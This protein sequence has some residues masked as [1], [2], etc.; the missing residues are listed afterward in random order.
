MGNT[1]G[2]H[3]GLKRSV[4]IAEQDAPTV[5]RS[6]G[7]YDAN[8]SRSNDESKFDGSEPVSRVEMI[9]KGSTSIVAPSRW[10]NAGK[11]ASSAILTVLSLSGIFA[12]LLRKL[13]KK[14]FFTS[15]HLLR[16]FASV[17]SRA[18]RQVTTP[19]LAKQC[20]FAGFHLLR[21]FASVLLSKSASV[22]RSAE[23]QVTTL[24]LLRKFASILRVTTLVLLMKFASILQVTTLV[25][26][27]KFASILSPSRAQVGQVT[28]LGISNSW[29]QC[30]KSSNVEQCK[31]SSN[32]EQYKKSSNGEQCTKPSNGE[33]CMKSSNG[34][35]SSMKSSNW[36]T[37]EFYIE[38]DTKSHLTSGLSRSWRA[39]LA[40]SFKELY[41]QSYI[42]NPGI[43]LYSL[44]NLL[45]KKKEFIDTGVMSLLA[46]IREG[47]NDVLCILFLEEEEPDYEINLSETTV[48]YDISLSETSDI[49]EKSS[50]TPGNDMYTL[51]NVSTKE[52]T[53]VNSTPSE[54][55]QYFERAEVES[56]P[57]EVLQYIE[58]TW[59]PKEIVQ[60]K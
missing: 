50:V 45:N 26:L 51:N 13:V 24:V 38:C 58:L 22:S 10:S 19:K 29:E 6:S 57:G 23:Q 7:G 40:R 11:S 31:K 35:H 54:A 33:Q 4:I 34:K 9:E 48:G 2:G 5:S 32:V 30:M 20:F 21:K 25:L 55:L 14:C 16:K 39:N 37:G 60:K 56:T 27:R 42:W 59:F 3:K 18:E 36:I 53:G 15:F 41:L 52:E 47:F 44:T 28:T 43:S 12:G 46:S 8:A 49:S 1:Q 17:S